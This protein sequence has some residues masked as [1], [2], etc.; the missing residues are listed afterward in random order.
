M[1]KPRQPGFSKLPR[2]HQRAVERAEDL[3]AGRPPRWFPTNAQI[4]AALE[5]LDQVNDPIIKELARE[6]ARR[7]KAERAPKV[8]DAEEAE[9]IRQR[10][11][12][13]VAAVA[14]LSPKYLTGNRT[15]SKL[16]EVVSKRLGVSVTETMIRH[17][18]RELR[19]RDDL[20]LAQKGR[21]PPQPDSPELQE[22]TRLE[23]EA[24]RQA[25]ARH[26]EREGRGD[27]GA[28]DF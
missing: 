13:L 14:E 26:K 22:Q 20:K 2:Q 9:T 19:L 21:I 4:D 15:I 17:D 27:N 1:P 23:Q 24:G 12:L 10:R 7:I 18:I 16:T 11:S 6:G 8:Q 28:D 3:Q 25:V 5:R